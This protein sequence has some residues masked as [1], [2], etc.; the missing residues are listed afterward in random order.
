MML[1]R[2]LAQRLA[3][4]AVVALVATVAYR[5]I[6]YVSVDRATVRESCWTWRWLPFH[7]G[8]LW[9]YLSMFVIVGLPWLLLRELRQVHR[10]ALCLLGMAAVGW[11][12]FMIYP[13]ACVRPSAEGQPESYAFL[14]ALDRPNNCLPCLHSAMAVLATWALLRGGPVILRGPLGQVLLIGWLATICISIVALRQHT[15]V[16]MLAG[17]AL[18]GA[19]AWWW[20]RG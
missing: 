1:K 9:P 13:T 15:D 18:G 5:S 14:L 16:D 6:Q 7:P 17:M 11:L 8:W 10:F 2:F 12:I 4:G 20:S 19:A 3:L